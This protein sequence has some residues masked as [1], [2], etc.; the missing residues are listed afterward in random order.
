[1]FSAAWA[2]IRSYPGPEVLVSESCV[3][4][5]GTPDGN[6]KV[7]HAITIAKNIIDENSIIYPR[8]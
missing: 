5:T 1:M 7:M 8:I 4:I 6:D 2:L 3:Y